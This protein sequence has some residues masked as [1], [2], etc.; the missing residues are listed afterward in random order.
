MYMAHSQEANINTSLNFYISKAI[1]EYRNSQKFFLY[2]IT[3]I[4]K[5]CVRCYQEILLIKYA[6]PNQPKVYLLYS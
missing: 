1:F 5:I 3:V 4:S 2:A 6:E